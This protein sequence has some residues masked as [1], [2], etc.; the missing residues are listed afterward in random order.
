MA[1]FILIILS[2]LG[3]NDRLFVYLAKK[4]SNA[5]I[6]ENISRI[7][8]EMVEAAIKEG[9][10]N[11]PPSRDKACYLYISSWSSKATSLT[12]NSII[13]LHVL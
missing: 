12:L 8:Q 9:R 11:A 1:E 4:K 13:A 6:L 10:Q 2:M 5:E 3:T 7:R